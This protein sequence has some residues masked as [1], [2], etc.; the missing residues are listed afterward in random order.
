MMMMPAIVP[1]IAAIV[2]NKIQTSLRR[3]RSGGAWCRGGG[4]ASWRGRDDRSRDGAE[5]G[6][7][8]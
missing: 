7:G 4:E 8:W 6:R 5:G 3:L 1:T 2:Q